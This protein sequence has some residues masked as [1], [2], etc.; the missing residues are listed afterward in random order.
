MT[1]ACDVI[2]TSDA[3]G[4]TVLA[5]EW[6]LYSATTGQAVV[7]INVPSLSNGTVI[8]LWY[9]KASV[10]TFQGNVAGTWDANYKGVWHLKEAGTGAAADYKDSTSNGNNS[11]NT[12]NE[13]AQVT[14]LVG[15]GESFAAANSYIALAADP[16]TSGPATFSAWVNLSA[17]SGT[18]YSSI[19]GK[20]QGAQTYGY[21]LEVSYASSTPYFTGVADSGDGT[22]GAAMSYANPSLNT[23]YY[24]VYTITGIGSGQTGTLYIN[25]LQA[26]TYTGTSAVY[27]GYANVIG[28][29]TSGTHT[30]GTIDEA[31]IS[32]VV[33]STAWITASYNNQKPG[34]TFYTVGT[35]NGAA[36]AGGGLIIQ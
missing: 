11:T 16:P 6:E 5:F 19:F 35:D 3:A 36:F 18:I 10:T 22:W 1:V 29:S 33:R 8:Y 25:G 28:G 23:W 2:F 17:F 30:V 4:S 15:Y 24:L 31:R 20:V 13:P 12:T 21:G 14:G 7:W 32:N 27:S 9:G 34:S 26:A